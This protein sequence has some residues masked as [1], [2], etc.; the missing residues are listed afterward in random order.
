MRGYD[1][2]TGLIDYVQSGP[3][4]N[5]TIQNLTYEWDAVGSLSRRIDVRQGLTEA[6]YYDDLHRLDY[7][8]LNGST[9]LDLSY[10]AMGNITYKSD[11][12]N[13]TY[14]ATKKHAVASTA[15]VL[16]TW[17]TYDAN[18][19]IAL[20][21]GL[22]HTWYSYNLP[23]KIVYSGAY[24]EFWYTPDRSR[25]RQFISE[26]GNVQNV[27]YVGGLFEKRVVGTNT[28]YRHLI[29]GGN[30]PV[31][32]FERTHTG[33]TSTSYISTDHLGG[34]SVLTNAAGARLVEESFDAFGKRRN[35]ATWS[36]TP[37]A[38][39][40]SQIATTTRRGFTFHEHLDNLSLIHMNGRVFDPVI[41]RFMS[42]DPFIDGPDLTQGWN[43]YSY[44]QGRVMSATDPSGYGARRFRRPGYISGFWDY[45]FDPAGIRNVMDQLQPSLV[46]ASMNAYSADVGR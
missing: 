46:G 20:R 19:N 12:G 35:G 31:A 18:G 3:S 39:D 32:Y 28:E 45:I 11:V 29:L 42:A 17:Y 9:N 21:N 43:R 15:G 23:K 10:D 22:T 38:G 6:F 24:S 34:T 14:H 40:M 41:G 27:Y 30:G 4:A 33:A 1:Q 5:G 37:S 2:V 26:G 16:N 36:G 7:S 44:V 13:Y 8:T 25:R